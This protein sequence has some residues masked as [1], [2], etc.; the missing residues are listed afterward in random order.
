MDLIERWGRPSTIGSLVYIPVLPTTEDDEL[1][2]P[3]VS[4]VVRVQEKFQLHAHSTWHKKSPMGSGE[5][6]LDWS[7]FSTALTLSN[8]GFA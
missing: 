6:T 1:I 3:D 8:Y 4:E 2:W 7:E 5:M